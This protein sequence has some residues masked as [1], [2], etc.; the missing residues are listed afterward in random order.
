METLIEKCKRKLRLV[1]TKYVR[2]VM[3][4]IG[5]G[6]RLIAIRGAKGVGK[7]TLM[8]QYLKMHGCNGISSLYITMDDG[9]F[10][11]HSLIEL[12]D[13]FYK[14]GGHLLMI[15]EVHKYAGW[16]REIKNI[17][18]DYPDLQVVISSSSLLN[19][20]AG[21]ADL[22]RRC[23]PYDIYGLSYRE[24][25]QLA[26]GVC[27][28][29][30][31]LQ[32]LLSQPDTL[33]NKVTDVCRPLEYFDEYLREGYYPFVLEDRLSYPLKVEN[34][35]N[36]ILDVELPHLCGV[37]VG[38][39]RKLKSLLTILSD[40]VPM[41][42]D[43]SK[44]STMVEMSRLTLLNHL[45]Y[46]QRARLL[47][48]LYSDEDGVK[49]LQKPDK[50][51]L[52]NTNLMDVLSLSSVNEG[53]QRET[54]LVGQMRAAGHRVEYS[55]N[56]D[57]LVDGQWTIEVGGKNKDGKQIASLPNAFIAADHLDMPVGNKIP[58]WA[59]GFVY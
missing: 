37:D 53:T 26:H 49:K 58:L 22:S 3:N 38:Q 50:I 7:T 42:V 41:Q 11:Q 28:E 6:N 43:I 9:Y 51:Y 48:L 40:G 12:A 24:Y 34:V 19:I 4:K 16:S 52:E 44:M 18:D 14:K 35:V 57:V 39:V 47:N 20:M 2:D 56:G 59:F 33:C 29:P 31:E 27:V 46:L 45:Q 55:R 25:L 8:L 54:F 1:Q 23:V 10:T 30:I 32:E 15:D 36:Y 13:Q 17:Y 21:D 5:W